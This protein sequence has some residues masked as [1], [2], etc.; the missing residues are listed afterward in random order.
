MNMNPEVETFVEL[1]YGAFEITTD[2]FQKLPASVLA[3][4]YDRYALRTYGPITS[5]L[6]LMASRIATSLVLFKRKGIGQS[7][8]RQRLYIYRVIDEYHNRA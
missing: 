6:E 8:R 5:N 4:I 3:T 7:H 1:R 2:W